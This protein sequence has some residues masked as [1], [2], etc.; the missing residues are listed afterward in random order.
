MTHWDVANFFESPKEKTRVMEGLANT[1]FHYD[2]I[3]N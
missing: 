2:N 3:Q 1:S